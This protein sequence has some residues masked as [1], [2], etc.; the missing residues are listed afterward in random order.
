MDHN[1]I[2]IYLINLFIA[3]CA[4]III[5]INIYYITPNNYKIIENNI[6]ENNIKKKEIVTINPKNN[7]E[8]NCKE[9]KY[10]KFN[11]DVNLIISN[12]YKSQNIL[13]LKSNILETN[14]N[15]KITIQNI[16][17]KPIDLEI[18]YIKI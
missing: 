3:V 10:Y 18:N 13:L 14:F 9:T 7:L 6:E 11:K 8:I 5:F 12:W 4:L 1:L 17:S 15:S 16:T 2:K